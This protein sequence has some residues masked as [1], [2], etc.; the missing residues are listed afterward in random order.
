MGDYLSAIILQHETVNQ[1][2]DDGRNMVKAVRDLGIVP[3]VTLDKGWKPIPGFPGEV[4]TQGMDDLSD[5]CKAYK[6]QGL[7]FA[8]W[9]MVGVISEDGRLPSRVAVSE[10]VKELALYALI[11]QENGIVPIIEPDIS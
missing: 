8:K 3:G 2:L 7:D 1:S 11:C 10:G 4:F 9:R 5:R 6:S